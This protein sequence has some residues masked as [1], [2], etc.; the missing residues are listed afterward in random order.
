MSSQMF[1]NV[2]LKNSFVKSFKSWKNVKKKKLNK[3]IPT[4]FVPENAEGVCMLVS[5]K[6]SDNNVRIFADKFQVLVIE[7]FL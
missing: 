5:E 7:T 4:F 2:F 6:L 3:I 1:P